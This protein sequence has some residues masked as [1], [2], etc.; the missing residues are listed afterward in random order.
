MADKKKFIIPTQGGAFRDM[1]LR[2]KLIGNLMLDRRVNP[3]VKL[4]PVASLV[5]LISPVDLISVV[6]VLSA[7]DDTAVLALGAYLFLEMCPPA[8]VG[9]Y[10]RRLTSNIDMVNKQAQSDVI[11]GEVVDDDK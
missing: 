11:D 6:P 9:E 10:V 7:L 5:Y 2:L 4:I 3:L 8:V 1:L